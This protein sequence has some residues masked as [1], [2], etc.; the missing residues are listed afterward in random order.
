[1][2][3]EL[4]NVHPLGRR[5]LLSIT[6]AFLLLGTGL[7][8]AVPL[9]EEQVLSQDAAGEPTFIQGQ[10]GT[11]APGI[12]RGAAAM[13]FLADFAGESLSASGQEGFFVLAENRDDLGYVHVRIVQEI[14]G[15]AVLGNQIVVHADDDSGEVYAVTGRFVSA[16]GLASDPLLEAIPALELAAKEMGI[17]AVA[18]DEPELVYVL[19]DFD[20]PVLAWRNRVEYSTKEG[21][22][23]DEIFADAVT[24]AVVARH[25]QVHRAKSWR[26]YTSNNTSALPGTLRCTNTQSCG[27]SVLQNVHNG[28]SSVYDYYNARFGRRSYNGSDATISSVGHH[29][30]NYNNAFWNGS[31]L[32]YGD[33][34]GS[35]FGPLGN[36][37]DVVAHEFTH[38]VTQHESGLIY[39]N[40]SGALNEA[41][42]DIFGAGAEAWR[43]GISGDT[44]KIGEDA[45]TPGI[46]GDALRYMNNPTQDGNSRDYYPERYTGSADNGGVHWNSGIAN[47]A[48]YLAVN[49]GQHPRGKTTVVVP[50]IGLSQAEQIFYRAQTTYLTPSSN[51]SAARAA[52]GQAARDLYGAGS[53]NNVYTAWC[54]V[55]VG[56]CP[57]ASTN[58]SLFISQS[59][60]SSMTPG[61]T[62]SVSI[63]MKN[64][65]TT[66]WTRAG[67]YKLGS[68]N[69]ED[70]T[71]WGLTR[72]LLPTSVSVAPGQQRTFTFNITAPT[73]PGTYN[74]QWR[75]VQDFVEW[76][77]AFTPNHLITVSGGTT[78]NSQFISQSVPTT[79]VVGQTAT[80]SVTMK[81]TGTTTWTR[82]GN[83]KL[84]SQNPQDNLTW[85]LKRV[86]LPSTVAVAPGQQRT[87]T[88]TIKAPSTPGTYNFQW[89]M[90]QDGVQWFGAFST[91]K[92]IVVQNAVNNAQFIAYGGVPTT[93]ARGQTKV[94]SVTLKNTGTTTWRRAAGYKLGSE[95]PRDNRTWNLNRVWLPSTVSVAPGQQRTFTFTIKA[96]SRAGTYDF[97]WRM[98]QDGVQWFGAFSPN[99][100][101]VV[102]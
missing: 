94:V 47:L 50:S 91:N 63:T 2:M 60:P 15:L 69:P 59:V 39:S 73:T 53:E 76:F 5:Y 11:L 29:Q 43:D 27:D 99:R 49:G 34:D 90:V 6:L 75:M 24:G 8:A 86:W 96:P 17:V 56:S 32:V 61:Q 25:P 21:D 20:Q 1:M 3:S 83:Y 85:N 33:G 65:G 18:T 13:A 81:N 98:V 70:N 80:V 57:A 97:Q 19:D 62:A 16:V 40:E 10:L 44:W 9:S 93:M 46:S 41:W 22:E 92:A 7:A 28:A 95:N 14:N 72:V 51:F 87:F 66:T 37:F 89:R 42:S 12:D 102:N 71:R 4:H 36:A 26:T 55:G 82:S 35:Q 88:F 68:Q 54:A 84:G 38:A 78:N 23:I 31:Y 30:T 77:G 58:N 52:T 64:T 74:F 45:Y 67:S 79:M 48:F 101:I 100:Q